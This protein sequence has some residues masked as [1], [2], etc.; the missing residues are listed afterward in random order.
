MEER[1]KILPG[2]KFRCARIKAAQKRYA[3]IIKAKSPYDRVKKTPGPELIKV[4]LKSE[5]AVERAN[6]IPPRPRVKAPKRVKSLKE[7]SGR[8][9]LIEDFNGKAVL[10]VNLR[11]I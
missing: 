4:Q 6:S 3:G 2:L 10:S 1:I 8:R 7:K 9:R 11:K 5:A